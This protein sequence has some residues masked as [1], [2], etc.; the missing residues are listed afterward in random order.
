MVEVIAAK[1][2]SSFSKIPLCTYYLGRLKVG[3]FKREGI[4]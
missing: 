1:N 3:L 2:V 4:I